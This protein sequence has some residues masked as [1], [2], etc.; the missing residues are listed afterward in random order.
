VIRCLALYMAAGAADIA[1][2]LLR[3]VPLHGSRKAPLCRLP[4]RSPQLPS[5]FL[6]SH[7]LQ[8]HNATVWM[9][10]HVPQNR[11]LFMTTG[12]NGGLNI[13]KWVH[14]PDGAVTVGVAAR[15]RRCSLPLRA[16]MHATRMSRFSLAAGLRARP[17]S[18]SGVAAARNSESCHLALLLFFG[19]ASS[20]SP[21][22]C[23]HR[24]RRADTTTPPSA[25]TRTLMG[26]R[27]A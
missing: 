4:A 21:T 10:K 22:L 11:D 13:Y 18:H 9:A 27:A 3:N 17:Q 15:L 23:F 5:R 14:S 19:H 20:L 1:V 26:S 8:A 24:S 7:S 12:G 16:V 2:L 25:W 6:P